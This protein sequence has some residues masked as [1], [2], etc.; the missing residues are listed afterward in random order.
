MTEHDEQVAVVRFF[1]AQY[2]KY[3]EYI[4][5]IPN[6]SVLHKGKPKGKDFARYN[7]MIAEGFKPGVSDLF[8]AIPN[9]S[10][11]GLWIEMKQ[12]KKPSTL[13]QNQKEFIDNMNKIGYEAHCA[14]GCEVAIEIIKEYMK[15]VV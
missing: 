14:K 9:Q 5:S 15:G 6:G 1:K 4:M 3:K 8:I 12:T 10:K 13:K 11:H 7:W 2:P